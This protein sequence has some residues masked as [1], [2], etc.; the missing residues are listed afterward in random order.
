METFTFDPRCWRVA[1]I[2]GRNPLLRRTDRVEALITVVA[3]LVTLMAIPVAGVLGAATYGARDRLYT[4]EAQGRHLVAAKVDD[5]RAGDWGTTLV[6][7]RW[8]VAAGQRTGSMQL[9]AGVKSGDSVRIWL[10]K[11]GE[12]SFPPT[13]ASH[14]V[15]DAIG[16]AVAIS[17]LVGFVMASL[18]VAAR[19]W[20][21]RARAAQWDR[22]ITCLVDDGRTNR[23]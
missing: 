15:A 7:V 20:L 8:P 23:Q 1:R 18:V 10:D 14:A 3:V 2:F 5:A 22:A 17:L 16:T 13:P 19:S 11:D 4:Q 9:P 21:D 6:Q 12:P